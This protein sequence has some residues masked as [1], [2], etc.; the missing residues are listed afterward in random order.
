MCAA[1]VGLVLSGSA[2]R[3]SVAE[4]LSLP[5]LTARAEVVVF[6]QVLATETR[7]SDD[8]HHLYRRVH[9]QVSERWKGAA[10]DEVILLLRG[11]ERD[12]LAERVLGV[13]ELA[14]GEQGVFFLRQQGDVHRLVGLGQGAFL[15]RDDGTFAPRTEDLSLAGPGADGRLTIGEHGEGA[16]PPT[17]LEALRREVRSVVALPD[18]R[19]R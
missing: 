14:D 1:V 16:I 13:P 6:A 11:G 7:W 3:A 10:P 8:H 19:V 15:L 9:L 4:R 5:E 18:G 17:P 2:A 12:G